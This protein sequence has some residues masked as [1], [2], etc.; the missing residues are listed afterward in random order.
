MAREQIRY[1]VPSQLQ[2]ELENMAEW[3]AMGNANEVAR[4]LMMLG[5]HSTQSARALRQQS[6]VVAELMETIMKAGEEMKETA[7]D[8]RQ[9]RMGVGCGL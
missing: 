5:Y 4:H 1:T 7:D 3:L 2:Q 6:D 8:S 9:L